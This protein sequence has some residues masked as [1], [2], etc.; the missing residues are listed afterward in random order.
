MCAGVSQ[1]L[2]QKRSLPTAIVWSNPKSSKLGRIMFEEEI[3]CAYKK[4][5]EGF[6]LHRGTFWEVGQGVS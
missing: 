5:I 4:E 1:K 6:P 2:T 3:T